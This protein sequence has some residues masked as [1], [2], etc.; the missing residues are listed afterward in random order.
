MFSR[1]LISKIR[2]FKFKVFFETLKYFGLFPRLP[3]LI[4][5]GDSSQHALW[6]NLLK[7]TPA[8]SM[9]KIVILKGMSESVV[10]AWW[11]VWSWA[12]PCGRGVGWCVRP[13]K[14]PG[15][16]EHVSMFKSPNTQNLR[17]ELV[18]KYRIQKPSKHSCENSVKSGRKCTTTPISHKVVTCVLF[19]QRF[20]QRGFKAA[21]K[22]YYIVSDMFM[23]SFWFLFFLYAIS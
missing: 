4:T 6:A 2:I 16:S 9:I 7:D 15:E 12:E 18:L 10:R 20:R 17:T 13:K 22:S 23:I 8:R 3:F 19:F 11:C 21:Y 1:I 5:I 14:V